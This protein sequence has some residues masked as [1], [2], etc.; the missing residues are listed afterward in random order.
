MASIVLDTWE[1]QIAVISQKDKEDIDE[2]C[3][4]FWERNQ[5]KENIGSRKRPIFIR[6]NI[7][8]VRPHAGSVYNF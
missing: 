6:S 3:R 2:A 1:Q 7:P 8:R 4:K 5:I